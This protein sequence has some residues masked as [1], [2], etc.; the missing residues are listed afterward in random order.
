M[1]RNYVRK[2]TGGNGC[3]E[4]QRERARQLIVNGMH[5]EEGRKYWSAAYY[6]AWKSQEGN[7][8]F[9]LTCMNESACCAHSYAFL[10]LQCCSLAYCLCRLFYRHLVVATS[11]CS[12]HNK[13]RSWSRTVLNSTTDALDLLWR[14]FVEWRLIW[15]IVISWIIRLTVKIEWQEQTGHTRSWNVRDCHC[16]DRAY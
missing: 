1:V 7:L 13:R 12:R 14:T 2:T 10:S 3:T 4:I 5:S 15:L 6:A 9:H 16:A 11:A 8:L